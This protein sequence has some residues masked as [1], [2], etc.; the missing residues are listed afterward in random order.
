LLFIIYSNH[1]VGEWTEAGVI[2]PDAFDEQSS[3][4]AD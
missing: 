3:I 1:A 4:D 2:G